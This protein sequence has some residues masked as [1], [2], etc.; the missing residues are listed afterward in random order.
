MPVR[1]RRAGC[2]PGGR[3]GRQHGASATI[4]KNFALSEPDS[5]IISYDSSRLRRVFISI[6]G[7]GASTRPWSLPGVRTCTW[8]SKYRM[9]ANRRP[10]P[11]RAAG[12]G[13]SQSRRCRLPSRSN[14]PPSGAAALRSSCV[15]MRAFA[16]QFRSTCLR[17][18]EEPTTISPPPLPP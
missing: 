1:D 2:R 14:R 17:Q 9:A 8:F 6:M 7:P 16:S 11:K 10:Q 5:V 18:R 15:P 4:V 12:L 13:P 3:A